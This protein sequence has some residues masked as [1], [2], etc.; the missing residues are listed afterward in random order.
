M[1]YFGWV[2]FYSAWRGDPGM[3]AAVANAHFWTAFYAWAAVLLAA[4][5]TVAVAHSFRGAECLV[6]TRYVLSALAVLVAIIICLCVVLA[7]IYWNL[8]QSPGLVHR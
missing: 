1:R 7:G 3:E 8:H 6:A 2:G 5:A 4:G